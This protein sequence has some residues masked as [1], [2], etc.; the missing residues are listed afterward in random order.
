ME[1]LLF[2]NATHAFEDAQAEDPRVRFNPAAT[3]REYDLLRA[4]I[5][6]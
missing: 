2:E 6:R 3:A 4:I 1:I 5:A